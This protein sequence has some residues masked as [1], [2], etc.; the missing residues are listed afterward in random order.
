MRFA[1]L[2]EE[3]ES[4]GK[5]ADEDQFVVRFGSHL[6]EESVADRQRR[7]EAERRRNE[8]GKN[9]HFSAQ[10]R[11]DAGSA[12]SR[13]VRR[14]EE[15][16]A[17]REVLR[18]IEE[19]GM[20]AELAE[21]SDRLERLRIFSSKNRFPGVGIDEEVVEVELEGSESAEDDVLVFDGNC[22]CCQRKSST[23]VKELT[24]FREEIVCPSN[25]ELVDL[26]SELLQLRISHFDLL[27]RRTA[28]STLDDRIFVEFVKFVLRS[29]VAGITE[30]EER[31]VLRE[32][33]LHIAAV[34]GR[35]WEG[36]E[37]TD[38]NRRSGE[39]NLSLAID[40]QQSEI[41]S[42]LYAEY[43]LSSSLSVNDSP[44]FLSRCPSSARSNPISV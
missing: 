21:E 17:T 11:I 2:F 32:I 7:S 6:L 3:S 38:L 31:E 39:Q 36:I 43:Q 29:E 12:I 8:P 41:R 24:I 14:R 5:I 26:L 27:V 20:I 37:W 22:A 44:E 30:A 25:D 15:A 42:V 1:E 35:R 28:V 9:G 18:E 10:R 13:I 4:F 40:L 19:A 16:L 34:S 33:V 23:K